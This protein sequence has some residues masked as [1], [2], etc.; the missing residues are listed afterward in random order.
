[1]TFEQTLLAGFAALPQVSITLAYTG[2]SYSCVKNQAYRH[3]DKA[4]GGFEPEDILSLL[5]KTKDLTAQ[6]SDAFES[7]IGSKATING[8]EWRILK[9]KEGDYMTTFDLVSPNQQ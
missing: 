3:R 9:V 8:E 2:E 7:Y 1:M 5:F 6:S 4:L